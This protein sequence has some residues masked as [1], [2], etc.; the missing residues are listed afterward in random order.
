L[1]YPKKARVTYFGVTSYS[2]RSAPEQPQT[3]YHLSEKLLKK[4]L[5]AEKEM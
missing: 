4:N 1:D 5:N 2:A 3:L